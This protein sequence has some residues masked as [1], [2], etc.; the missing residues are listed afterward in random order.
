VPLDTALEQLQQ[1]AEEV[2]PAFEGAKAAAPA[3]A[4]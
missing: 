1:F 3:L 4:K 2:I